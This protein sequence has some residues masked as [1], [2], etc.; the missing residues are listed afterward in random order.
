MG[1]VVWD[2]SVPRKAKP[3]APVEIKVKAWRE[4]AWNPEAIAFKA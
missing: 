4:I 2:I 1:P 3:V